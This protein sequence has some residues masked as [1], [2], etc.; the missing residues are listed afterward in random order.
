MDSSVL[1][2]ESNEIMRKGLSC[3]LAEHR[4][5]RRI[6]EV[7]DAAR[8]LAAAQRERFEVAILGMSVVEDK[9]HDLIAALRRICDDTR[10][11]SIVRSGRERELER[12]IRSEAA[13]IVFDD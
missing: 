7:P 9:R 1:L 11:I 8:A 10:C 12:V 4:R 3:A 13:G 5:I 2:V 6:T